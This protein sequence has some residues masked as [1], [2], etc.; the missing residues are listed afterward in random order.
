MMSS[1]VLTAYEQAPSKLQTSEGACRH[2]IDAAILLASYAIFG[3]ITQTS[4]PWKGMII[5]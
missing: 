1:Q 2:C 4:F 5:G 3:L